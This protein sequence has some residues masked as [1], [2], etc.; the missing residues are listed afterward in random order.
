MAVV[1]QLTP[2]SS[3]HAE[4]I[5]YTSTVDYFGAKQAKIAVSL[6]NYTCREGIFRPISFVNLLA[7]AWDLDTET[8]TAILRE[9]YRNSVVDAQLSECSKTESNLKPVA[10]RKPLSN[11]ISFLPPAINNPLEKAPGADEFTVFKLLINGLIKQARSAIP[12]HDDDLARCFK[13][14]LAELGLPMAL[15]LELNTWDLELDLFTQTPELTRE[16]MSIIVDGIYNAISTASG[17]AA[18]DQMLADVLNEMSEH[19]AAAR[20]SPE[21]FL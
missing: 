8:K 17:P 9:L 3:K 10:A 14:A 18:A 2:L 21:N 5:V 4:S 6:V 20:F 11:A 12:G 1:E 7:T 15:H 19:S 16:K 13:Q